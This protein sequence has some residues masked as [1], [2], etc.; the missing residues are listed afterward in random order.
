M[1][2]ERLKIARGNRDVLRT[3]YGVIKSGD[4]QDVT[5]FVL[6]T[7]VSKFSRVSVFSELNNLEDITMQSEYASILGITEEEIDRFLSGYIEEY[8]KKNGK[9]IEEARE[10]YERRYVK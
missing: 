5:R 3:F 8:S 6:L 1:G 7:G 10:E 4:V 2:E 9:E